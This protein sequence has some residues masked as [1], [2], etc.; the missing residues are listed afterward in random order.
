MLEHQLAIAGRYVMSK[1]FLAGLSTALVL[2]LT[3]TSLNA[4][5]LGTA[6]AAKAMLDRAIAALRANEGN[7]LSEFNDPNNKSFHEQDLNVFCFNTSDGKITAYSSPGLIGID[8]RTLSL[9]DDPIGQRTYD[10]AKDLPE[11]GV[12]SL[13]YNFP[14][15]GTTE[16]A[17]KRSLETRVGNQGCAVAHYK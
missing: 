9:R 16:P 1:N 3:Q 4:Q 13:E 14:K 12:A 10:V 8:I 15:P 17:P 5:E 11:A 6:E 7:A 2:W